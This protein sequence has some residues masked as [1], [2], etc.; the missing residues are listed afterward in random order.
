MLSEHELGLSDYIEVLMRRKLAILLPFALG[1]VLAIFL[2]VWLPSVYRST[3]R[4]LIEEQ[5]I[6]SDFVR[7]S[8]TTFADQRIQTI[9]QHVMTRANLARVIEKF[10]L[11]QKEIEGG[12]L[13]LVV[14]TMRDAISVETIGADIIDPQSGRPTQVTI[15]FTVAFDYRDPQIAQKVATEISELFLNKNASNRARAADEAFSFLAE[16]AA[17]LHE[18]IRIDEEKISQFKKD[19]VNQLPELNQINFSALAGLERDLINTNAQISTLQERK[20]FLESE[21]GQMDPFSGIITEKGDRVLSKAA[22]LELLKSQYPTLLSRYSSTHPNL[23]RMRR[24]MQALEVEL[25]QRPSRQTTNRELHDARARL[26]SLAKRYSPEHPDIRKLQRQIAALESTPKNSSPSGSRV[27]LAAESPA[28]IATRTRLASARSELNALAIRK[29]EIEAKQVDLRNRLTL[30]PQV[31]WQYQDLLRQYKNKTTRYE[32]IKTKEMEAR[33][34]QKMESENKGERFSLIE[35]AEFPLLPV[36]PNRKLILVL[37]LILGLGC[38]VA[39]VVL[40]EALDDSIHNETAIFALAGVRPIV[41]VPFLEDEVDRVNKMRRYRMVMTGSVAVVL[42][43]AI[44]IV[45]A[46]FS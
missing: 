10:G 11:Y 42:V 34:S 40:L 3:A 22:K 27:R 39:L 7:S 24:E 30:A 45:A 5:D 41:T 21:L 4:I 17:R 36:E 9:S 29:K 26:V 32:D 23:T 43:G 14:A 19:N 12:S 35:P 20:F 44:A 33:I 31:E 46:T 18:G 38:G 1:M 37:G 16:E 13:E 25:G 15:A 6:P 28:Y 2:A 8:V